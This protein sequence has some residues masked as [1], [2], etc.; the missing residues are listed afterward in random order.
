MAS[1]EVLPPLIAAQLNHLIVHS[2]FPVKVEKLWSGSKKRNLLDRFT[3][4]I[5]F[6]LDHIRWDVIYNVSAPMAAPDVIFGPDDDTFSAF[7]MEPDRRG[8]NKL[9]MSSLVDWNYRES[10]RLLNLILEL[11]EQYAAYQ[12][13]RVGEVEDERIKFEIS[14]ISH[15][16]GIEMLVT[17]VEKPEEVKFGVPLLAV[18]INEMVP[19]CPWRLQQKIQL[20]VVFPV[21]KN[22]A[23]STNPSAPRLKL[24]SSADLRALLSVE[25]VKLPPWSSGMCM[26]EYLPDLEDTLGKQVVEC[27]SAIDVRRRFIEAL[28]VV[29]GRPL[30]A[31]S[32]FCRRS[33]FLATSGVFTFLVHISL[34]TQF[35]RQQ[36]SIMLQSAQHF[37]SQGSPIK[38]T[39]LPDYPWSPR[40]EA[41]QMAERIFEYL[42]EEC[43]NFKKYCNEMQQY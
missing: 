17:G 16:G 11:R 9:A 33:S 12:R 4:L 43:L 23:L 26:A 22:F 19:G 24:V 32:V 42:V 37:N 30:E 6:C 36:P 35:P 34:P 14:T 20:Q 15:R 8:N 5:P 38:S 40:W 13:K 25:D 18:N 3:L 27:I 41:S 29:F 31:D 2:P 28:A 7:L 1:S 39:P 21:V 10:F